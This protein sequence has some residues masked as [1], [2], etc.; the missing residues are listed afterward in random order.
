MQDATI[1]GQL[2]EMIGKKVNTNY[3]AL[4]IAKELL[5]FQHGH[6]FWLYLCH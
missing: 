5:G 4:L 6:V 2:K 1:A 3:I